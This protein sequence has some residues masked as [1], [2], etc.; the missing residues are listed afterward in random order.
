Y[1]TVTSTLYRM[2]APAGAILQIGTIVASVVLAFLL[3]RHAAFRMALCAAAAFIVSLVLWAAI[4][5]PVNA[6]WLHALQSVPGSVPDAYARLRRRWAYGHV[7]AC[8]A[9]LIGYVALLSAALDQRWETTSTR[10]GTG[11]A[12]TRA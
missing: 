5:A 6:A 11:R 9:W 2:F 10:S 3:R 1:A 4:V 7:A 8:G 12:R